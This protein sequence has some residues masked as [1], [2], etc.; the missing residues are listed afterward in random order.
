[1]YFTL[2]NPQVVVCVALDRYW[3][4]IHAPTY[5]LLQKS[6]AIA[7]V[8]ITIIYSL[9]LSI[10]NIPNISYNNFTCSFLDQ[11]SNDFMKYYDPVNSILYMSTILVIPTLVVSILYFK[12]VKELKNKIKIVQTTVIKT[13]NSSSQLPSASINKELVVTGFVTT[14]LFMLS[15]VYES[16]F[17]AFSSIG[18]IQHCAGSP[19]QVF[20]ICLTHLDACLS[21]YIYTYLLKQPRTFVKQ[22]FCK[23]RNQAMRVIVVTMTTIDRR[24]LINLGNQ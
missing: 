22:F 11:N 19:L 2:L 12:I 14:I 3:A 16:V 5:K 6:R 18:L 20:G 21:P 7:C 13:L 4:I 15:Y 24:N 17:T 9:L 10:L 23:M 1:M 8:L